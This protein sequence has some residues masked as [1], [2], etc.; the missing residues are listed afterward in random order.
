MW[1][2]QG[3]HYEMQ[4]IIRIKRNLQRDEV[5]QSIGW[6]DCRKALR[7]YREELQQLETSPLGKCPPFLIIN[8]TNLM[9]E[10]K[11]NFL[12]RSAKQRLLLGRLQ[13]RERDVHRSQA[14]TQTAALS[15]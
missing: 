5:A 9:M 14:A 12:G 7:N 4:E 15:L 8:A 10:S 11:T 1:A 2:Q 13:H 6:F 3:D